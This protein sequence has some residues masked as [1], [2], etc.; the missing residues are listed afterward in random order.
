MGCMALEMTT[1]DPEPGGI[2][3]WSCRL[4][5]TTHS[6]LLAGFP[7]YFTPCS[8][9]M[10]FH[11]FSPV[12]ISFHWSKFA[13]AITQP[14]GE[15]TPQ[16]QI[17]RSLALFHTKFHYFL[18]TT[19]TF[20]LQT[21]ALISHPSYNKN[22]SVVF[23]IRQ[24]HLQQTD[25]HQTMQFLIPLLLSLLASTAFSQEPTSAAIPSSIPSNLNSIISSAVQAAS[26]AAAASSI[27]MIV[28]ASSSISMLATA[29]ETP[30]GLTELSS[31]SSLATDQSSIITSS[32][33]SS[34]SSAIASITSNANASDSAI[35]SEIV[36]AV[37]SATEA[38]ASATGAASKKV[39][40]GMGVGGAVGGAALVVVVVAGWL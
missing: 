25:K 2:C 16:L 23:T 12:H 3:S 9:G 21:Q 24:T 40:M 29:T 22:N 4:S 17:T 37:S 35:S 6:P 27:D 7:R 30:P 15:P 8:Y 32:L 5:S 39:S 14:S 34:V 11:L 20:V 18:T 33:L 1:I 36:G 31:S 26:T 13:I 19:I 28:A 38:A 10:N